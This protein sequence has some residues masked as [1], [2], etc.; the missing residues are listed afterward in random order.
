MVILLG[1]LPSLADG[2]SSIANEAGNAVL[3]VV[4]G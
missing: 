2:L 3:S 4:G 1:L